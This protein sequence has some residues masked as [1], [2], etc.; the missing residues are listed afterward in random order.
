MR[1][2]TALATV[3]ALLVSGCGS[4]GAGDIRESEQVSSVVRRYFSSFAHGSGTELCPLLTQ[5][6]Q[7]KMVEV[8]ESDERELGRS[9]PARACP[10]AVEFF[11][12]V[13]MASIADT[14]VIAVSITGTNATVTVNVGNLPTGSVFLSKT[15]AGWLID[16]LPGQT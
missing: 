10:E 9:D 15:V 5:N 2:L 7:D 1:R 12:R 16:E 13:D 8:V 11:R 3:L 14:K 6:A 4:E